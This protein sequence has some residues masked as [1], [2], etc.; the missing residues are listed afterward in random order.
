MFSLFYGCFKYMFAK[1][2]YSVAVLGL[3]GSGKTTLTEQIKSKYSGIPPPNPDK[4]TPTIGLNVR[5]V[6]V[7]FIKLRLWDLS[8]ESGMRKIWPNYYSEADGVIFVVDAT[9]RDKLLEAKKVFD[10]IVSSGFLKTIP[11]LIFLNKS[12]SPPSPSSPPSTA[13]PTLITPEEIL[14]YFRLVESSA[15]IIGFTVEKGEG[16][17]GEGVK[18]GVD[19]LA[20]YMRKYVTVKDTT[21]SL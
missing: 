17:V 19:W 6:D 16:I 10:T 5:R 18:R 3:D 7:G 21:K 8:G 9:N 20:T 15:S 1:T 12:S 4:I 11:V 13:P 14:D 2:E